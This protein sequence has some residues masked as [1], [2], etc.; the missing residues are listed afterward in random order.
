ML[1][2]TCSKEPGDGGGEAGPALQG[3]RV[4]PAQFP[5]QWEARAWI[6][7]KRVSVY[8]KN[9]TDAM[10]K[11]NR[12]RGQH[13]PANGNTT[14]RAALDRWEKRVLAN[15]RVAGRELSPSAVENYQMALR[16]LAAEFG[17]ASG[18]RS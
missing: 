4:G 12:R 8:G 15:K 11:L 18:S 17:R 1:A 2:P 16:V 9:K 5:G 10:A 6:D 13:G 7:G 3:R 14:V